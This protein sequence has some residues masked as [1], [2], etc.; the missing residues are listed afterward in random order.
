MTCL[1]GI[2]LKALLENMVPGRPLAKATTS[3]LYFISLVDTETSENSSV[4]KVTNT[5]RLSDAKRGI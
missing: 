4:S 3:A 5:L 2:I 1:T